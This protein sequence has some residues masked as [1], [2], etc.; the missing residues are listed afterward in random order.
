[1]KKNFIK[2]CSR[3]LLTPQQLNVV[4]LILNKGLYPLKGFMNQY[5]Y[6]EVIENKT[7][8][9]SPWTIPYTYK[10]K[11]CE[12]LLNLLEKNNVIF[13]DLY[14]KPVA[15][16]NISS[17]FEI[18]IKKECKSVYGTIDD[19]HP[20]V[21]KIINDN[22]TFC[23]GGII[24]KIKDIEHYDFIEYRKTPEDIKKLK[25][26]LNIDALIGFQTRN[27]VH[28]SHK[29]LMT[30]SINTLLNSGEYKNPGVLLNP[31]SGVNQDRD[32]DLN[33]RMLC[34][35]SILPYLSTNG[36]TLLNILPYD[37]HMAGPA[38]A[39]MH[40][41]IRKNFGC[42]HLITGRD[43]AG[44]STTD[45]NGNTFYETYEAQDYLIKLSEQI[46]IKIIPSPSIVY[47][48]K[49]N[50]YTTVDKL[51][52]GEEIFN[53]SGSLL[54][55]KIR[56]D[57]E[58]PEWF[59][60]PETI[61]ILKN[62]QP[63]G[64]CLYFTGL[65]G[66]GK[67]T[68]ASKVKHLLESNPDEK[69]TATLLDGDEIRRNLSKGLGFSKK[70]R[71]INVRR[72]GYVASKLVNANS[73]VLCSNIAP[74]HQDREYNRKNIRNYIEIFCDSS[75][76]ECKSRDPKLNYIIYSDIKNS[77]NDYEVPKNPE[78]VLDTTYKTKE[79]NSNKVIEY[80]RKKGYI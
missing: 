7:F 2:N 11:K 39:V 23:A 35:K 3:I 38:E 72:I 22:Y 12:K 28:N 67:T 66:S 41:I 8:N 63:K 47:S 75:V 80:L 74:Y 79:T 59:S 40:A 20:G 32:I 21:K 65:S 57:Q 42:T 30:N 53:I 1:M 49:R 36:N 64:F 34:Y 13:E 69:R 10:F 5:E 68:I 58:V 9:S 73:I 17:I 56:K 19:N 78:I 46:G 16:F 48:K 55:E 4:E 31:V 70:D 45:K 15:H 33:T 51:E 14:G 76:K 71:S 50:T 18:D 77:A 25:K 54:R 61:K 27:P 62:K 60:C 43:H 37:M 29:F 24:T 6:N 52:K 44:P 26:K